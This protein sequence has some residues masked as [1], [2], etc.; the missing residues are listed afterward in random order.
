M[1]SLHCPLRLV[2]NVSRED[3]AVNISGVHFL[4]RLRHKKLQEYSRS[5]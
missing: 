3:E 1:R 5:R 4:L 2:A